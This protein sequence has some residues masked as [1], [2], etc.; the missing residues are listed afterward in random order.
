ML[1][2]TQPQHEEGQRSYKFRWRLSVKAI[3]EDD[4]VYKNLHWCAAV[5]ALKRGRLQRNA[6]DRKTHLTFTAAAKRVTAARQQTLEGTV[7]AVQP[8]TLRG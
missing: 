1:W 7:H 5:M 3:E 4:R 8:M 6:T 2:R